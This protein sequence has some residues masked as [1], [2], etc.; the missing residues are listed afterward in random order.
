M[1]INRHD[2]VSALS[3]LSRVCL[4]KERNSTVRIL[5][6][7]QRMIHGTT[8]KMWCTNFALSHFP[9]LCVRR[10]YYHFFSW[11]IPGVVLE[12]GVGR[13]VAMELHFNTLWLE[14]P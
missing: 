9:L 7:H 5:F 1:I 11:S 3:L 10:R 13:G 2:Y 14:L 8:L 6:G 12:L 4:K